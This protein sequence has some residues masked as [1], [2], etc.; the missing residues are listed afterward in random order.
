MAGQGTVLRETAAGVGPPRLELAGWRHR[1]GVIAGLTVPGDRPGLPGFDLG[2]WTRRPVGEVMADWRAFREAEPG[3]HGWAMGHQVHGTEVHWHEDVRGWQVEEGVDGHGTARAG[4]M[5]LVTVADCVP[6]FLLDPAR[7]AIALLHAGWRGASAGILER[8]VD[9]LRE[10]AGSRPGD[11][12]L[13]L[14]PAICGTCYEVGRE[15]VEAFGDTPAGP[16]PWHEDIRGRLLRRAEALGIPERSSSE[17]CTAHHRPR[18]HSHRASGGTD[19]R[20]V[21]YLGLTPAR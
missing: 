15:V 9:L 3:F 5:L 20:M 16:G 18:F 19:G 11:L 13:H 1:H 12:L 4:V 14:G 21:A 7:R 2:L 17:W 8:G 6:V 10:R